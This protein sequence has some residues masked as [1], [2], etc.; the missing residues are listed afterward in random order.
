MAIASW[1]G[2]FADLN[3]ARLSKVPNRVIV[4]VGSVNEGLWDLR[5]WS[6]P[7]TG[8]RVVNGSIVSTGPSNFFCG[9]LPYS[10]KTTNSDTLPIPEGTGAGG[11]CKVLVSA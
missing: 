7:T 1:V 8:R 11:G 9:G 2:P 10:I 3:T 4:F 5:G 6:Y